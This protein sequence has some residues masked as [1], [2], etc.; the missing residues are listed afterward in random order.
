MIKRINTTSKIASEPLGPK[1]TK[2]PVLNELIFDMTSQEYHSTPNTY[3][4]SQFKDIGDDEELFIAKYIDKT[5]KREELDAFDVGNYFHTAV[6]EPH[7]L[8]EDFVVF[9]KKVRRGAEW[10]AFKN[11]Y[12]DKMIITP[13]QIETATKLVEAVEKSDVA[14][15]YIKR[16][17]P[18]VSLFVNLIVD[19]S[20]DRI[21]APH[22]NKYLYGRGLDGWKDLDT[23][24]V[25]GVAIT[26]KVRADSLGD[27]FILDLKSTTGN[28]KS[29]NTVRGKI[30]Y[31]QYELSAS[32]YVD[33]FS[34]VNPKVKDFI[35]T[36][37]SKDF[38][39]SKSYKASREMILVGRAK[40]TQALYKIA[41][42]MRN[43]WQVY[44]TMG[45]LEPYPNDL[46]LIKER[47]IDL[48]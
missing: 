22:F 2:G 39:N 21:I 42:C 24:A 36:F 6:L 7:K 13:N 19:D 32:L 48:L 1:K 29:L 9:Q 14:M 44:D 38:Y 46:E 33:L 27:N 47:A 30:S 12:K 31:Y 15:A 18:E 11:K 35:W 16:G 20:T 23:K 45:L 41:T 37:A 43:D 34:L 4:S 25:G 5:I 26:V 8:R 3:S 17:K 10:E 28:A 40:W